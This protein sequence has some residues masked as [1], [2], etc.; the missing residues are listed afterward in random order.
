[1]KTLSASINLVSLIIVLVVLI[2]N[3]YE[4]GG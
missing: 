1:M 4:E 3:G 2:I